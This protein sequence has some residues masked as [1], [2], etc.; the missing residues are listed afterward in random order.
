MVT[1]AGFVHVIESTE[2]Q[3]FPDGTSDTLPEAGTAVAMFNDAPA[4]ATWL[5]VAVGANLTVTGRDG[6]ATEALVL[7]AVHV[8]GWFKDASL[9]TCTNRSQ[10]R[11]TSPN[12]TGLSAAICQCSSAA[13]SWTSHKASRS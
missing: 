12:M 6:A 1:I 8:S 3:I 9:L 11:L 10:M 2:S 4:V 5:G 13:S 7:V